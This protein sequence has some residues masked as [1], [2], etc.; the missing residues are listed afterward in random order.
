MNQVQLQK[1]CV[2]I[3]VQTVIH[4]LLDVRDSLLLQDVLKNSTKNTDLN[5]NNYKEKRVITEGQIVQEVMTLFL[6]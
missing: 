6:I 2:L 5:N 4:S 1:N 3:L